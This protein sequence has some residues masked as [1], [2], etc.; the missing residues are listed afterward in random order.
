MSRGKGRGDCQPSGLL[1]EKSGVSSVGGRGEG[2][3]EAGKG[4]KERG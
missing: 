1:V 4:E 2:G 3:K